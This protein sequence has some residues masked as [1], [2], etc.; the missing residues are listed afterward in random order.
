VRSIAFAILLAAIALLTGAMVAQVTPTRML[1][2]ICAVVIFVV[3]FIRIDWGLYILI[4]SMLLSPEIIAGHTGS[5][6]LSRGVT[7]RL[8][9]FL[10]VLIGVSWFARNAVMK[11]LGLFLKTPLNKPI[12]FYMLTCVLSTGLGSWPAGWN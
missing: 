9:D 1:V 3:S 11:E 4:F 2:Y 6:S 10:L 8:E 5:S 7:L 12:L